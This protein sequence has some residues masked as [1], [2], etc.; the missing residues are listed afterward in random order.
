MHLHFLEVEHQLLK[1]VLVNGGRFNS[2]EN[3]DSAELDS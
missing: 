1:E 2:E 3:T